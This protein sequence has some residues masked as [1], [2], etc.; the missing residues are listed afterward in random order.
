[1]QQ[2]IFKLL[3]NRGPDKSGNYLHRTSSYECH[4]SGHVLWQQGASPCSQPIVSANDDN[5]H[6]LLLNGDIY[7]K[8]PNATALL[9]DTEWLMQKIVECQQVQSFHHV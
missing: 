2:D 5:Q 3:S 1:M 6:V 9:S 8:R 4:F 7:T